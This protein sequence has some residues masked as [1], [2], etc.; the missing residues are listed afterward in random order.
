M[1]TWA[2]IVV[3]EGP[4]STGV[5]LLHYVAPSAIDGFAVG[6]LLTGLCF[7]VAVAPRLHRQPRLSGQQDPWPVGRRLGRKPQRDYY[8]VPADSAPAA[9][10]VSSA[11][12]PAPEVTVSTYSAADEVQEMLQPGAGRPD[13][14]YAA[15]P[16]GL[17]YL[18][19]D[20][21]SI[22]TL[23][24]EAGFAAAWPPQAGSSAR[25]TLPETA[26]TA[27]SFV[28]PPRTQFA[29]PADS[30]PNGQAFR[31]PA[32]EELMVPAPVPAPDPAPAPDT[33]PLT[34]HSGHRSR[35]RAES[36]GSERRVEAR[37]SGPRHAAPS[38][39]FSTRKSAKIRMLPLA[40]RS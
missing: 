5:G 26:T 36:T 35:H 4:A 2:A 3:R 23:A 38:A 11:A 21:E 9:E 33:A 40:A 27:W 1:N 17:G 24:L 25:P 10:P 34:G 32:D 20:Y 12:S 13:S 22:A 29:P 8:A 37:R 15:A 39:R 28:P 14:L 19:A 7:I 31:V 18:S 6:A 16:A 30:H